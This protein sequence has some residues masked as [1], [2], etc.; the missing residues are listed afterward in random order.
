VVTGNVSPGLH[1]TVADRFNGHKVLLFVFI[2][3]VRSFGKEQTHVAFIQ[4]IVCALR[5]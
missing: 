1:F 2:S 3:F 4:S 5:V